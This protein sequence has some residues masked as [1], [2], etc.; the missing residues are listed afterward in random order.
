MIEVTRRQGRR[1]KKI[2]GDLN[3]RRGYCQLKEKDLDRNIWRDRLRR[4]F[5]P[6][7]RQTTGWPWYDLHKDT[8]DVIKIDAFASTS[9]HAPDSQQHYFKCSLRVL[10]F[11]RFTARSYA[12]EL[13]QCL[14]LFVSGFKFDCFA[15]RTHHCR[16]FNEIQSC[17]FVFKKLR[18]YNRPLV[19]ADSQL[20]F[21][22][23]IKSFTVLNEDGVSTHQKA[24]ERTLVFD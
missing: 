12:E 9:P 11:N 7:V 22:E 5:E 20:R 6:V 18:T 15:G 1:R 21:C 8:N 16:N 13:Q 14:K 19:C 24:S 2:L 10:T 17:V 4:G 23:E 3:D